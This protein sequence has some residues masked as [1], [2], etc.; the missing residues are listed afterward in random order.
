MLRCHHCHDQAKADQ[1]LKKREWV[2]SHTDC[3]RP[4]LLLPLVGQ[5]EAAQHGITVGSEATSHSSSASDLLACLWHI[6][7]F[8]IIIWVVE[9]ATLTLNLK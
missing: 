4:C 6:A 9:V 8:K 1:L 7:Y 5:S 2:A 3:L